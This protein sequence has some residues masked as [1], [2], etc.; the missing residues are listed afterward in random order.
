MYDYI[1]YTV[2]PFIKKHYITITIIIV[3]LVIWTS[4]VTE[5]ISSIK[6]TY[7]AK[8]SQK[9]DIEALESMATTAITSRNDAKKEIDKAKKIVEENTIKYEV[10]T[11]V[12][13]CAKAQINR[14]IDWLEYSLDYCKDKNNLNTFKE[15]K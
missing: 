4:F 2:F 15:K 10:W 1:K 3:I 8:M 13:R 9:S 11:L 12:S 6:D 7:E 5:K 14:K